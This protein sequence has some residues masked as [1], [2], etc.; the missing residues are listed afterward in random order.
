MEIAHPYFGLIVLFRLQKNAL[1]SS[2]QKETGFTRNCLF[3][4]V[5]SDK[6]YSNQVAFPLN[7][8]RC[9]VFRLNNVIVA[10]SIAHPPCHSIEAKNKRTTFDCCLG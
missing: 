9:L 1:S 3:S 2:Q 8:L 7:H 5:I 4:D 6:D 10:K